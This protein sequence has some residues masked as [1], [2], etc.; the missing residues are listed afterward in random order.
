LV[1]VASDI[2]EEE[3]TYE[4][5]VAESHGYESHETHDLR[6]RFVFLQV[7]ISSRVV[8][9][10]FAYYL[11]SRIGSRLISNATARLQQEIVKRVLYAEKDFEQTYD[12]GYLSNAFSTSLAKLETI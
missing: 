5:H 1:D 11:T 8:L 2:W 12:P 10:V 9:N 4:G 3:Q 6:N 7:V